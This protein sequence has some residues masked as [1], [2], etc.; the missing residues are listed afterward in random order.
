MVIGEFEVGM[1]REEETEN[2]VTN[3]TTRNLV[4]SDGI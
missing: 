4:F 3:G 2:R 1:Q